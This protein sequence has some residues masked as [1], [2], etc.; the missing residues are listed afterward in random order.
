MLLTVLKLETKTI[1]GES[2]HNRKEKMIDK[3]KSLFWGMLR[4][5]VKIT[6][7]DV[8]AFEDR[9][10]RLQYEAGQA[11]MK[12]NTINDL[13]VEQGGMLDDNFFKR[14]D[15]KDDIKHPLIVRFE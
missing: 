9:A 1:G 12:A 14:K 8:M 2:P 15:Y 6:P 7:D 10:N 13:Y 4:G 5:E 3:K 11:R